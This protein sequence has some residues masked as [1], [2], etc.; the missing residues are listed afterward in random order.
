M[1]PPSSLSCESFTPLTTGPTLEGTTW[2]SSVTHLSGDS[3]EQ[4]HR[5]NCLL[6]RKRSRN[7]PLLSVC[8]WVAPWPEC[9]LLPWAII[10]AYILGADGCLCVLQ[11]RSFSSSCPTSLC[12]P[13]CTV[14]LFP[15]KVVEGC[16]GISFC[17]HASHAWEDEG[18]VNGFFLSPCSCH[19]L[20]LHLL[21]HRLRKV[22]LVSAR[23]ASRSGQAADSAGPPSGATGVVYRYFLIMFLTLIY[24]TSYGIIAV[25]VSPN[26]QMAAVLSSTFYSLW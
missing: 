3:C 21:F 15:S 4:G 12:R 23:L 26:V 14:R 13:S 24:F 16:H 6:P 1:P 9:C 8:W 20:L 5:A 25:A 10:P 11:L 2:R 18:E 19:H 7:V 22:L 17:L